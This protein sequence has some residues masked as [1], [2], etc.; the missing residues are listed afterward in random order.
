MTKKFDFSILRLRNFRLLM[1]TGMFNSL[2][3]QSQAVIVG[4]QVY[5]LTHSV[6]MLGLTGLA[7]A[8]PAFIAAFFAG[9]FVDTGHPRRIYT[10]CLLV[11]AINTFCLLIVAGGFAGWS[12]HNILLFIFCGVFISGFARTF[13][14]PAGFA[15]L[16]AIV[17]RADFPAA[18]AW[19]R[20]SRQAASLIGPTV[21]G[22]LYGGYGAKGAW[23]MLAMFI[24]AA[25]LCSSSL[26]VSHERKTEKREAAW[27]SIKAGW[28]FILKAPVLLPVMAL[29]MFAVLFGGAWAIM[30][31]YAD[32][33]L[34]VGAQGLGV[35]R[36]APGIGGIFAAL[37]LA[38]RPMKQ[39]TAVRMMWAI[40]G[41]G[42]CII[43]FGLSHVFWLSVVFLLAS[44]V[45]DNISLVISGT[46]IQLLTPDNMRGRISAINSMFFTSTNEIGAFES[47]TAAQLMGLVPSVVFGGCV[48]VLVVMVTAMI[49]PKLRKTSVSVE[50]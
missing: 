27:A 9:H 7:E 38:A 48:T 35:L 43:G 33:V 13:T 10:G 5:S 11:Q 23:L 3:W 49:S 17:A 36:A 46:L 28:E 14:G 31:A 8:L 47:G 12:D 19:S 42:L 4:W 32:Q 30:P 16:P 37:I 1:L 29:D 26:D 25:A 20:V 41:F 21:A 15:L 39:F 24:G 6:F 44:G 22:L 50:S 18:Y 2:A 45:A 40:A 34:H